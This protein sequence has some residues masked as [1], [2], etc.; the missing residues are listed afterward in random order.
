MHF[1]ADTRADL[2][3]RT[4]V[5][6]HAALEKERKRTTGL[7]GRLAFL[8]LEVE[9]SFTLGSDTAV[10]LEERVRAQEREVEDVAADA[11]RVRAE[12][13]VEAKAWVAERACVEEYKS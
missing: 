13:E 8:K 4:G 3:Y 2:E 6:E 11:E 1:T 5:G 10:R 7:N 9:S 12:V